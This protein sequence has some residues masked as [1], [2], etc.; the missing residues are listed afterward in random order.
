MKKALLALVVCVWSLPSASQPGQQKVHTIMT[1]AEVAWKAG[2]PSLQPGAQAAVLYGDPSKEG[3]F[4]MRLKLPKGF[5]IAPHT[6]PKPE[7]LT[8]VSGAFN[9]GMGSVADR[10]KARRLPSGS[11]FAFAPGLAHYAHVDEPTVVQ[12][13]STGPWT[14]NYINPADDPRRK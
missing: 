11:F 2:P 5:K 6:H 13:S 3:L 10:K 12:L 8:V 4:V 9:I 1:P 7:I 14:I